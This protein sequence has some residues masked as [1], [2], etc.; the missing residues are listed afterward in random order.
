MVKLKKQDKPESEEVEI[1]QAP[2]AKRRTLKAF[3]KA[4]E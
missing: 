2:V 1:K 4:L 3:T